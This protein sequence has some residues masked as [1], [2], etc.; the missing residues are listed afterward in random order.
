MPPSET[1][2]N[3]VLPPATVRLVVAGMLFPVAD[4]VFAGRGTKSS[5]FLCTYLRSSVST[6]LPR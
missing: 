5:N 4:A 1:Q 6:Y 3:N 2:L